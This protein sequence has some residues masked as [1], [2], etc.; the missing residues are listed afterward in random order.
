MKAKRQLQDKLRP[1]DPSL[2]STSWSNWNGACCWFY[3]Q[4]H[5]QSYSLRKRPERR[6]QKPF[7]NNMYH[8]CGVALTYPKA[9]VPLLRAA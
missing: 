8:L 4:Y 9:F 2:G 7:N 6:S 1:L 3:E 5:K